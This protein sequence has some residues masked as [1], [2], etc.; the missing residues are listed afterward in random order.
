MTDSFEIVTV[1]MGNRGVTVVSVIL[2][3]NTLASVLVLLRLWARTMMSKNLGRDD[4][5][6]VIGFVS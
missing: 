1:Y 6:L 5:M 4:M 3:F 2:V